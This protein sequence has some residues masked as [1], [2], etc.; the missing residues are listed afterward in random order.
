MKTIITFV[1]VLILSLIMIR[2]FFDSEFS[3]LVSDPKLI[4]IGFHACS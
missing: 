4:S 1:R 2:V 3:G